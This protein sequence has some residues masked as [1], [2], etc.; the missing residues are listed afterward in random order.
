MIHIHTDAIL[1][2][3]DILIASHLYEV[4]TNHVRSHKSTA[5]TKSVSKSMGMHQYGSHVARSSTS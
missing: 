4:T 1:I 2:V 3:L 5:F